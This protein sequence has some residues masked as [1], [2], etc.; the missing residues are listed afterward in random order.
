LQKWEHMS[1]V[2]LWSDDAKH[3]YWKD[4]ETDEQSAIYRLNA[5]G[6]ED[7]ELVTVD[8]GYMRSDYGRQF[9]L[10]RPGE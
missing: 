9:F 1:L 2:Q 10:K 3:F 4:D 7:R 6:N 8:R 5:L